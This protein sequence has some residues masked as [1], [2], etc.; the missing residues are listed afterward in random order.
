MGTT[1][2]FTSHRERQ[3]GTRLHLILCGDLCSGPTLLEAVGDFGSA[4]KMQME[5][6]SRPLRA[7]VTDVTAVGA[8]QE[9]L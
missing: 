1:G 6:R 9:M 7:F 5:N 4:T 3:V 8:R 2:R